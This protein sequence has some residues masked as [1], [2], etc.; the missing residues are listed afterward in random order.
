MYSQNPRIREIEKPDRIWVGRRRCV[1]ERTMSRNSCDEGTGG[2]SF[3][4]V[5]VLV[6]GIVGVVLT[7][8]QPMGGMEGMNDG[9]VPLNQHRQ[10]K[11]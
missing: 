6:G 2:I 8:E 3:H 7:L 5:C 11:N 10:K 4:W 1:R 9:D